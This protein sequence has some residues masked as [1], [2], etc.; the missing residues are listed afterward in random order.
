MGQE[1]SGAPANAP[2]PR[3]IAVSI[4]V[5]LVAGAAT[6]VVRDDG[7]DSAT[8]RAGAN[9]DPSPLAP[10]DTFPPTSAASAEAESTAEQVSVTTVT[11]ATTAPAPPSTA[12]EASATPAAQDHAAA[13]RNRTFESVSVTESSVERTFVD[14]GTVHVGFGADADADTVRWSISCNTAG[15]RVTVSADRL[16]VEE[17]GSSAAGCG[18][19]REAEDEWIASFFASGPSWELEGPRLV[20]RSGETVIS[21][22]EVPGEERRG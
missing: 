15:G 12:A 7:G 9:S 11:T 20:L 10:P 22:D 4:A 3:I 6:L 19:E 1:R 21:L 18:P 8:T 16:T 13:L 5:L 14:D 2:A 17:A